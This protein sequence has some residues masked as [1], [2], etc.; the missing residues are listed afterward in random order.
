MQEIHPQSKRSVHIS[1]G[2]VEFRKPS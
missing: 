1:N 2:T